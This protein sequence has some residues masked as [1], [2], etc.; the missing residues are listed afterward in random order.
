MSSEC[1]QGAQLSC[2]RSLGST[3]AACERH[4]IGLSSLASKRYFTLV[5]IFSH[6]GRIRGKLGRFWANFGQSRAIVC[7]FCASP[8]L[9][10]FAQTLGELG[11]NSVKFDRFGL[12]FARLG[13]F[14]AKCGEQIAPNFIC[15]LQSEFDR[16]GAEAIGRHRSRT[17]QMCLTFVG[18]APDL[19]DAAQNWPKSRQTQ[20]AQT[21][22]SARQNWPTSPNLGPHVP[23]LAETVPELA[24]FAQHRPKS[25]HTWTNVPNLGRTPPQHWPMVPRIGRHPLGL[26]Q[27][28]ANV[29][30]FGSDDERRAKMD[31]RGSDFNFH[32]GRFES[33]EPEGARLQ[34]R[35]LGKLSIHL[36]CQF[37]GASVTK[38]SMGQNLTTQ[39]RLTK[40]GP[41][42]N[43]SKPA[44]IWP[45]PAPVGSKS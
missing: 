34:I 27:N 23:K 26:D 17:G 41:S 5:A 33:S 11:P 39:A 32:P 36:R 24:N 10:E 35:P 25:P 1:E 12:N 29:V 15:M 37:W 8:T 2:V 21:W 7:E 44:Q 38:Q 19:A 14:K 45:K 3:R 16:Y 30:D 18:S 13:Q 20:I 22:P 31:L 43:W 42:R 9:V 6:F 4:A 40:F 28:R